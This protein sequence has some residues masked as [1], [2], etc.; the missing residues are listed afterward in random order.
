LQK[1]SN[2]KLFEHPA[3][4]VDGLRAAEHCLAAQDEVLKG[5]E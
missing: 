3:V 5:H 4:E 2:Q 1:V